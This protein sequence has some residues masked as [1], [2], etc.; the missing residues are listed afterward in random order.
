[1]IG[2]L[3]TDLEDDRVDILSEQV[4]EEP[5]AD[6]ALPDNRVDALLFDPPVAQAEHKGTDVGTEHDDD[7]IDDNK[8]GQESKEEQPEPYEDV[9]LFVD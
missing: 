3:W 4:E 9:D 8:A 6:V 5:V 7:A 1:M 2:I